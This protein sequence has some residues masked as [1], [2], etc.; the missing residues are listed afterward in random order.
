[1]GHWRHLK[2][3][4]RRLC[5]CR[6][7]PGA[8]CGADAWAPTLLCCARRGRCCAAPAVRCG[9]CPSVPA[10]VPPLP[11]HAERG[12]SLF[13][14]VLR[15]YPKRLDLW[16][17]YLDQE[18]AAGEQQRIRWAGA[19]KGGV[20]G[21]GGGG[22]VDAGHRKTGVFACLFFGEG[23]LTMR[24]V[25]WVCQAEAAAHKA[26]HACLPVCQWWM[27]CAASSQC[28]QALRRGPCGHADA[29]PLRRACA[30]RSSSAPR[31]CSCRPRR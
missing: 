15:N 12:R 17:V 3:L 24:A 10:A 28:L 8:R 16:S 4:L 20:G 27:A 5:C 31:T 1:M 23:Q 29:G 26:C 7:L 30:G 21:G 9:Q 6:A 11:P 14:G 22:G 19:G 25:G 13:E 18:I 2:P